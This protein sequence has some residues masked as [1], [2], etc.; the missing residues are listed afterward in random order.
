MGG[1]ISLN[2]INFE[3]MKSMVSNGNDIIISTLP[4][5]RQDCLLCGT[6]SASREVA[7]LNETLTQGNPSGIRV[8]I[9]GENSS[10]DTVVPKCE[11]LIKL[12]FADIYI[13]VGG[14]FEWLLLQDIYGFELFPTTSIESDLLKFK[15]RRKMSVKLLNC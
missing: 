12:G 5:Q 7:V 6:L 10:D 14:L 1:S 4:V 3:D 13:Y 8:V 2:K 11:Q 9:Y 15:G